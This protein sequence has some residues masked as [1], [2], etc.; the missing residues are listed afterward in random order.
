MSRALAERFAPATVPSI[1]RWSS[2]SPRSRRRIGSA[3]VLAAAVLD[4]TLTVPPSWQTSYLLSLLSC[5]VLLGRRRWPRTVYLLTIPGLLYGYAL[6]APM[7]A[8]YAVVVH[9]KPSWMLCWAWMLPVVIG[10]FVEF[11]ISAMLQL[12][13][14]H[15]LLDLEYA[16]LYAVTPVVVGQL[17]LTRRRLAQSLAQSRAERTTREAISVQNAVNAERLRISREL[18]DV[19]AHQVTLVSIRAG[20]LS[21]QSDDPA[22]L[23]AAAEIRAITSRTLGELRA[24]LSLLNAPGGTLAQP[25]LGDIDELVAASGMPV[26]LATGEL[27]ADVDPATGRTIYR[28][29]QESLTNAQRYAPGAS[30]DV[31][32][33]SS[34]EELQLL[35]GNAA[36]TR[37][38]TP[39]EEASWATGGAGLA[40]LRERVLGLRGTFDAGPSPD[41]GWRVSASLPVRSTVAVHDD[42]S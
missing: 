20:A 9:R 28:I 30:I 40:G 35:V 42:A 27:P 7:A 39:Q 2:W 12:T 8:L 18:H 22:V 36:A 38:R 33:S 26:R 19:V 6:V 15:Q 4:V 29:V 41:G 16:L 13:P 31:R 10:R 24:M 32:V 23:G 5:A 1:G 17:V 3:G 34:G 11:P 37:V 14:A 25:G 21:V